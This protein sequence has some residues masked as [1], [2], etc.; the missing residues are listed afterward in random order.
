M[1]WKK[2]K[3]E[4]KQKRGKCR[5]CK[6]VRMKRASNLPQIMRIIP[7]RGAGITKNPVNFYLKRYSERA[8]IEFKFDIGYY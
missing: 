2:A 7:F 5:S 6:R 8:Q 3:Q 4:M 1:R